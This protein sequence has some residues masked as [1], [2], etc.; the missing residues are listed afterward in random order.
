MWID[1]RTINTI[2][3]RQSI[4]YFSEKL[5]RAA[6]KYPIYDLELYAF[7]RALKNWQHYLCIIDDTCQIQLPSKY[8]VSTIFDI[9]NSSCYYAGVDSRTNRFEEGGND[10]DHGAIVIKD[11][12]RVLEDPFNEHIKMISEWEPNLVIIFLHIKR[13]DELIGLDW[14][15]FGPPRFVASW[16]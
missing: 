7:V 10:M 15:S 12:V 8:G 2:I 3:E 13:H 5:N 11:P 16:F 14:I 9:T 6:L 1:Y 4:T